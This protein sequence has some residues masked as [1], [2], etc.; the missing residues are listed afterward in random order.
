MLINVQERVGVIVYNALDFFVS[1]CS[2]NYDI[3]H[4]YVNVNIFCFLCFI[5]E[6]NSKTGA[7]R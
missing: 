1:N 6:P 5:F 7:H 2:Q 3:S 4:F